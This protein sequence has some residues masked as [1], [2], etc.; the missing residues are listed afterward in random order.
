MAFASAVSFSTDFSDS[1]DG[2][3][4]QIC[5]ELQL[6]PA[7]YDRAVQRYDTLNRALES[8]AS[9]FRH[10]TPEIYPQGSMALGTTVAPIAG[11]HDLDFVLQLARD[12]ESVDPMKLIRALYDFLRQH[13]TYSSM[14]SL[15]NRC[16]RIEYADEFYMDV[17]PACR[18]GA[19]GGTCLKVP[20]R[21]AKGWSDSNPLGYV[22]WF[23]KRGSI[24]NIDRVLDRAAP[25]PEQEAV[26]EKDTLQLI[27]QL[28]KRWRD[29]YYRAEPEL[30][31]ISV[32]LTTLA[33]LTYRGERSVSQ[34][35]SSAL[36]GMLLLVDA[37]RRSGERHL[38]VW[39]PSNTAEDLSER[40]DSRPAAYQDV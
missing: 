1:L 16:V 29:L 34:A 10:F 5:D 19:V 24:L 32:V 2:L 17:L 23:K 20:D 3:L 31:P 35:L 12:H 25:I 4:L 18:N 28:L 40:W 9:P 30:A 11:P 6:A 15:K 37:S 27:V 33:G 8:A 22:K 36:G 7:R 21:A 38:R 39:N 13:G 26:A 14:T